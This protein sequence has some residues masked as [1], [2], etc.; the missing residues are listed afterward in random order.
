MVW[1]MYVLGVVWT[2]A[3]VLVCGNRSEMTRYVTGSFGWT[4]VEVQDSRVRWEGE[5][6]RRKREVEER[7]EGKTRRKDQ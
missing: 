4:T 1:S 6:G 5:K 2:N 3:V 7:G